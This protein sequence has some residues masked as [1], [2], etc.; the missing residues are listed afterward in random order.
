M[1]TNDRSLFFLSLSLIC[2]WVI[3][4]NFIGKKYLRKLVNSIVS[5]GGTGTGQK[6]VSELQ[7]VNNG[8]VPNNA[9]DWL[10]KDGDE[11]T[12]QSYKPITEQAKAD[13]NSQWDGIIKYKNF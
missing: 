7:Q 5:D 9:T 13:I 3:I 1:E 2:I 4:D 11:D 12:N 10:N 8:A 6:T